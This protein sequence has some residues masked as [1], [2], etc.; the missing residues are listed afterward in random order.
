MALNFP[1][2]PVLNQLYIN[3]KKF[4]KWDGVA[5]KQL[6]STKERFL[7]EYVNFYSNTTSNNITLD[8]RTYNNFEVAVTS[9]TSINVVPNNNLFSQFVL[10]LD[11]TSAGYDTNVDGFNLTTASYDSTFKN[12][13][14][15]D[16]APQSIF[17]KPDGTKM[18]MVGQINNTVYQYTLSTPW[19]VNTASYDTVSFSVL[20]QTTLS[21]DIFF[22]PDGT[23]MY[24]LE[25]VNDRV[26]QYTLSTPWDISTA[27]YDSIFKFVNPEDAA[28]NDIFFKPDGTKMYMLGEINDQMYQYTLSTPWEVNT[29][30]YD[31][32]SFSV[33]SLET[34]PYS[35]YFTSDGTRVYLVGIANDKV[36]QYTLSTPWDI[37]TASYDLENFDVAIQDA[38]PLNIF[39]KPDGTKMYI[40]GA[41]ADRVYQYTTASP[42][43][44]TISWSDNVISP[45]ITP[46]LTTNSIIE[47]NTFGDGKWTA[48]TLS[49]V[50]G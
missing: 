32:V 15:Q 49:S 23:K 22:K 37:S 11:Y 2:A 36:Y 46:F 7:T 27:S 44:N 6:N 50:L 24:L 30:S 3:D 14:P 35:F 42:L 26:H 39:F 8:L 4:Y 40:L 28:P 31:T 38:F 34:Q 16:A 29:A 13:N 33:A 43:Y 48:T 25:I 45:P 19:E 20:A 1:S 21:R 18:Y 17:F 47:F 41:G 12:V 9:N 10:Q 5:W